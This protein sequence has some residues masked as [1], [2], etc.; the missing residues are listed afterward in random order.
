M[1]T[2]RTTADVIILHGVNIKQILLYTLRKSLTSRLNKNVIC[3]HHNSKYNICIELNVSYE[4][5]TFRFYNIN[6][7]LKNDNLTPTSV[8]GFLF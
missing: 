4:T 1:S 2:G 7:K 3:K 5:E 8:Y 6:K